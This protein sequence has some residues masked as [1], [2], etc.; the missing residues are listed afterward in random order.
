MIFMELESSGRTEHTVNR[1]A[2]DTALTEDHG[3]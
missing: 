1:A 2:T 3:V